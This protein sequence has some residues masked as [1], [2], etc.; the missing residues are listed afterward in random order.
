MNKGVRIEK[1]SFDIIDRNVDLSKFSEEEKVVVKRVIHACGDFEF[2]KLI[3][4]SKKWLTDF[5][6]I[7]GKNPPVICDV[8]MV[9]AGITEKYLRISGL[10]TYCFI[11]DNEVVRKANELNKT[12]AEISIEYAFDKFENIIFVVGNAP[13]ALL[14]IV[15]IQKQKPLQNIFVVGFP[16]G[17]VKAAES[18]DL[19]AKSEIPFVTNRGTK[20]GSGIAAAAFNAMI[21][22]CFDV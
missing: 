17:F 21:K 22:V 14:K 11:S 12:R 1:E 19:L 13:T 2:A 8:N 10:N 7:L 18:K 4:F 3:H 20:G 15:E 9:K 6:N 16:V 5:K